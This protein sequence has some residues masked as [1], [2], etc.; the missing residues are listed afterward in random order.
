MTLATQTLRRAQR[1]RGK[2]RIDELFDQGKTGKSKL[3]IIK[4]LPAPVPFHRIAVIVGRKAGNAVARNRLKRRIRAA[5]RAAK[6]ALPKGW[7]LV[8]MGRHGCQTATLEEL[9]ASLRK[10]VLRAVNPECPEAR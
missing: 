1:L 5:Y 6:A 2:D 3:F 10:A 8:A 4:A 9:R 7:D